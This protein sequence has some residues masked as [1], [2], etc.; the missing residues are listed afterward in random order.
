MKISIKMEESKSD[1]FSPIAERGTVTWAETFREFRRT[2]GSGIKDFKQGG[3][4][5]AMQFVEGSKNYCHK[6]KKIY[7]FIFSM[8]DGTPMCV[9][10]VD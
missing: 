9:D 8:G 3:G 7:D 1:Y 5:G 2:M 4:A 6:H 10:C